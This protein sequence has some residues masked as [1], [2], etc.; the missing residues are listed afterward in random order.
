MSERIALVT[1]GAGGIGSATCRALAKQ[2]LRVVVADID[3]T[4]ARVLARD[5]PGER[6][7]AF[8][9]DVADEE[10]VGALFGAVESSIGPITV[11]VCIA[12]GALITPEHRPSVSHMSLDH[13][14][15]TNARNVRGTF[16]CLR[17]FLAA[18]EKKPVADARIVTI[19]SLAGQTAGTSETDAA[20]A[21]SKAAIAGLT[22]VVA[23][24][25]G[26]LGITANTVAPG[27][28]ETQKVCASTT[29]AQREA[30]ARITPLGRLGEPQEIA[31][32]I[33]FLA[34]P[35]SGFVTGTTL[36]ANGGRF[37]A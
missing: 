22:R 17:E 32:V 13:W 3:E 18:R 1:G 28:I 4:A 9:V 36:S 21:A 15:R 5:L 11:L 34:S 35:E 16:L 20:Y 29:P 19:G 10:S 6:H 30:A 33:A 23:A 26:R 25:A 24:Q 31:A 7:A 14:D 8:R 37:I 27:L 12:G 2:G